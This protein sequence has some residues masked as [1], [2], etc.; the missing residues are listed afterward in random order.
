MCAGIAPTEYEAYEVKEFSRNSDDCDRDTCS[1]VGHV[2]T[3]GTVSSEAQAVVFSVADQ[4]GQMQLLGTTSL[5]SG[6]GKDTVNVNFHWPGANQVVLVYVHPAAASHSARLK[7][8][9]GE[10]TRRYCLGALNVCQ[11]HR[12]SASILE[13]KKVAASLYMVAPPIGEVLRG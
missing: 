9:E 4:N 13:N 10:S 11:L 3:N 2:N 7:D 1:I 12:S 8:E 5:S 6:V